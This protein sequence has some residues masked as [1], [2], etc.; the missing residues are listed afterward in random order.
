MGMCR[1]PEELSILGDDCFQVA[2]VQFVSSA[3]GTSTADRFYIAKPRALVELYADLCRRF[4]SC[5]MVELGIARGGSTA[6]I[7]M[8]AKPRRLVALEIRDEPLAG[9]ADFIEARG[10]SD[11]VRPFYGVDQA[12]RARLAQIMDEEFADEPL[13][14]VIDDASHLL[15]ESRSSFESLF[16]RLRPG[17]IYIIEDWNVKHRW[18]DSRREAL[19]DPSSPVHDEIERRIRERIAEKGFPPKP[20]SRLLMELTLARASSGDAV[21]EITIGSFWAVIRRGPSKLD[22]TSFRVAD[23]YHD[24]FGLLRA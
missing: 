20:L 3:I 13:D 15:A 19:N 11:G 2:D 24:H 17:G 5:S 16:P 8:L 9:L 12:D 14:L 6:L 23:L 7:A 21:D 18:A 4:P 22:P 10:L 1:M